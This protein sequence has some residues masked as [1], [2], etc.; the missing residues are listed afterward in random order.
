MLTWWGPKWHG[1]GYIGGNIGGICK[2]HKE[3]GIESQ[4]SLIGGEG[5][6]YA[7][8]VKFSPE[9]SAVLEIAEIIVTPNLNI[10]SNFTNVIVHNVWR[11]KWQSLSTQTMFTLKQ[12]ENPISNW[13]SFCSTWFDPA[14]RLTCNCDDSPYEWAPPFKCVFI[15]KRLYSNKCPHSNKH[16]HFNKPPCSNRILRCCQN[17]CQW[18]FIFL[19]CSHISN[20]ALESRGL[21][22]SFST[23]LSIRVHNS[24][25]Q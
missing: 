12:V 17:T 11:A 15:N 20:V 23:I 21:H 16:L 5:W 9:L 4:V 2:G 19:N 18:R 22:R 1:G 10:S 6:F 7:S 8:R 3:I 24:F 25:K 14:S 13:S